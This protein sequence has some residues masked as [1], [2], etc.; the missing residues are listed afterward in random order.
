MAQRG[1]ALATVDIR[2][3]TEADA[4]PFS[5]PFD[6]VIMAMAKV[7]DIPLITN[8]ADIHASQRVDVYW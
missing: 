2:M 6:S 7:L 1:F 3:L 4:Y 5:D 8:D